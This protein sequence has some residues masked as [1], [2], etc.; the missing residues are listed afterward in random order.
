MIEVEVAAESEIACWAQ[1]R[2]GAW[3]ICGLGAPIAEEGE[4]FPHGTP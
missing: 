3:A 4:A 1:G 2:A